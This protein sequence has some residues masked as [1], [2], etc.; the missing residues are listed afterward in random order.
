MAKEAARRRRPYAPT[1]P[2]RPRARA[3]VDF[4]E[5]GSAQLAVHHHRASADEHVPRPFTGEANHQVRHS[6]GLEARAE[7][8]VAEER[9]SQPPGSRHSTL[10]DGSVVAVALAEA[11]E[12]RALE[13]QVRR[14]TIRSQGDV[15]AG[16]ERV[17]AA[18]HAVAL[19][20]PRVLHEPQASGVG[21]GDLGL[22]EV[23]S[24]REHR[25][26]RKR[27][28]RE[29]ALQGA[30]VAAAPRVVDV[31]AVL[32]HVHV[33]ANTQRPGQRAGLAQG[34]VGRGEGG[35]ERDEAPN[36]RASVRAQKAL[37]LGE[38]TPTFGAP[39]VALG[40]AIPD[41]DAHAQRLRLVGEHVER[42]LDEAWRLVVVEERGAP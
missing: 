26:G 5:V 32:G 16:R 30:R 24:M 6:A 3:R 42:A 31:G 27:V 37:A 11:K 18:A 10:Q 35:V 17:R 36:Q 9:A 33:H 29:Q 40:G 41:D 2:A 12:G 8:G 38:P 22:R 28:E 7:V 1:A 19:V 15:R 4:L 34:L 39:E 23:H 13:G 21:A 25:A 14:P 20:G